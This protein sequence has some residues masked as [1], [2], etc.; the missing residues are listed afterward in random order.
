[1]LEVDDPRDLPPWP[2]LVRRGGRAVAAYRW[3]KH[4]QAHAAPLE[5]AS[6]SDDRGTG[7]RRP[8][9]LWQVDETQRRR[10]TAVIEAL[11]AASLARPKS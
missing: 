1:M 10:E 5:D 7:L 8:A 11:I 2:I 4:A 6:V 9:R 3:D